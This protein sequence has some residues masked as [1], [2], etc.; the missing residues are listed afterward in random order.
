MCALFSVYSRYKIHTVKSALL[1]CLNLKNI[2]LLAS[3]KPFESVNK[4]ANQGKYFPHFQNFYFP[5][6]KDIYSLAIS[7]SLKTLQFDVLEQILDN[8][9]LTTENGISL[10][11]LIIETGALDVILNCLSIFTHSNADLVA[12]LTGKKENSTIGSGNLKKYFKVM[13]LANSFKS[14]NYVF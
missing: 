11:K 6:T 4:M 5:A 10:R 2:V 1:H 8:S 12:E 7:T 3:K 14:R 9:P 13:F